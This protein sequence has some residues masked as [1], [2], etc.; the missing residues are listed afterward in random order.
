MIF[1]TAGIWNCRGFV[2]TSLY[3]ETRSFFF[4]F[5]HHFRESKMKAAFTGSV[6]AVEFP[7]EKAFVAQRPEPRISHL[8]PA[9]PLKCST[10]QELLSGEGRE[11]PSPKFTGKKALSPLSCKWWMALRSLWLWGKK[12][13]VGTESSQS[14][15]CCTCSLWGFS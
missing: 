12:S 13:E 3:Q 15:R 4:A 6:A 11:S 9:L 8:L 10:P 5:C 7:R 1:H 14:Q 2:E